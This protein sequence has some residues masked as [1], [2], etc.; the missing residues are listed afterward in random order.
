[1]VD[2]IVPAVT[3]ESRGRTENLLGLR[4]EAAVLTEPFCQWVIEDDFCQ[5]RP[6]WNLGGAIFTDSVAP[7]ETMKLRLLNGAHSAIAYLGH[8]GGHT[9][10]AD[11]MQN[12]QLEHFIRDMMISEIAPTITAPP[13]FQLEAYIDQLIHR[14]HNSKLEHRCLQIA[15]DG[16]QKLPQRQLQTIADRLAAGADIS[17]LAL[18]VAA[19]M[20]FVTG[21]DLHGNPHRV[22][23]PMADVLE[24]HAGRCARRPGELVDSLLQLE[25]IF[26]AEMRQS[27]SFRQLLVGQVARLYELGLPGALERLQ[28]AV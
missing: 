9:F 2:R 20:I 17:H 18:A 8:L 5:Q 23:D 10:V 12:Q 22:D 4:D 21:R 6:A 1:M 14:F 15:M 24:A 11:C 3:E 27:K 13:G 7:F 28:A 26:S 16:S 19:W 25:S